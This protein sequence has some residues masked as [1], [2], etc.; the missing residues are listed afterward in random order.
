M[1][2]NGVARTFEPLGECA[3]LANGFTR[4]KPAFSRMF[5]T[6]AVVW[7]AVGL[8]SMKDSSSCTSFSIIWK[9]LRGF[10]GLDAPILL[11]RSAL[12]NSRSCGWG[13]ICFTLCGFYSILLLLVNIE[14]TGKAGNRHGTQ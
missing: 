4:E 8:P 14:S 3:V 1:R 6:D 13:R 7:Y 2:K 11:L 12:C 9:N 10:I 5:R